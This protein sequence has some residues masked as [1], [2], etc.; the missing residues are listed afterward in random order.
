MKKKSILKEWAKAI[1]FAFLTI[2]I[3]RSFFFEAFTIPSASM[4]KSLLTGDYI[5]VSKL[6]YGPRI[7]ITPLSFPFVHQK[8]PFTEN[9]NSFLNWIKI[10][11]LRLFG[12]PS[13]KHNDIVV[14]NYPLE[15]EFPIDQRTYYVKRCVAVSGDTFE[16]K[17]GQVFINN[18]YS[19]D[20][21]NLQ[22]NYRVLCDKDT[23]ATDTLL[24]SGITEGGKMR[25]KGEYWFN[26]NLEGVEK[27][28][29]IPHVTSVEPLLEQE[30]MYN[31]NMFPS[32]ENYS[33]NVDYFGPLYIPKAGDTVKLTIASLPLYERII[34]VYEKNDLRVRNDSIIINNKYS[35]SYTFKMNYFFMLG[36]NRHNST[37]SRF[38]GFV[39]ED[40]IV[41]KAVM[42]LLSIDK[43]KDESRVRSDRWFKELK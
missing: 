28:K 9:T 29:H 21:Q 33:W 20:P 5:L 27:L 1:L 30:T 6:S 18:K 3:I 41:G 11:Y 38:W 23:I 2:L 10:P 22:F 16:I 15:Q 4:E 19:D 31:E 37:D 17:K 32:N 13:I 43:S 24:K 8:L 26:L 14:F 42:V 40:H 25:N 34:G 36:D 7:P 12:S 35:T 39:P